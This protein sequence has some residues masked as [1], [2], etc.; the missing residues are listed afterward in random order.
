MDLDVRFTHNN[1]LSSSV[2][3]H[4]FN[5]NTGE[6]SGVDSNRD[7]D[8]YIHVE[9]MNDAIRR[10]GLRC[11]INCN[12]FVSKHFCSIIL[13]T[14]FIDLPQHIE[15]SCSA[16][17]AGNGIHWHSLVGWSHKDLCKEIRYHAA[18]PC[19]SLYHA[20]KF[21]SM[22]SKHVDLADNLNG[23]CKLLKTIISCLAIHELTSAQYSYIQ[24]PTVTGKS[25]TCVPASH[26]SNKICST[27]TASAERATDILGPGRTLTCYMDPE[28]F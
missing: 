11:F 2:E 18:I 21:A 22:L 5:S 28:L 6:S 9:G 8:S 23:M 14:G 7:H 12:A 26:V 19:I 15:S 17:E 27:N 16:K 1:Q 4:I 3:N 13:V 10:I 25:W 24:T 20:Y